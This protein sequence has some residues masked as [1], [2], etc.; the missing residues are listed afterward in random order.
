ML[1]EASR[2]HRRPAAIHRAEE[3]GREAIA[4]RPDNPY[5]V[6][7][8]GHVMEM[9]GRQGEPYCEVDSDCLDDEYCN[10]GV[11]TIGRNVCKATLPSG[12]ACTRGGQCESGKCPLLICN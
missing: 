8:V 3:L 12:A 4:M 11:L 5:A 6:H 1:I 10:T 2:I 9:K 7:A